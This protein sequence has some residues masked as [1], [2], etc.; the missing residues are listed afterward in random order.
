MWLEDIGEDKV[1]I[2]FSDNELKIINNTF[3]EACDGLLACRFVDCVDQV[4][5]IYCVVR[6]N[7][8]SLIEATD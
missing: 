5:D 8:Q 1:R 3:K 2:I 4:H 6:D 7:S